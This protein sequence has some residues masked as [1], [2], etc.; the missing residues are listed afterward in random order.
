MSMT[1]WDRRVD[2]PRHDRFAGRTTTRKAPSFFD[3][4]GGCIPDSVPKIVTFLHLEVQNP[5]ADMKAITDIPDSVNSGW[6][7]SR[8]SRP[9]IA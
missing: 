3:F 7:R 8:F 4:S 5:L 9:Y 1:F 6:N 2:S